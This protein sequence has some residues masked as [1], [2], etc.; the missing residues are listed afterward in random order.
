[1]GSL[2]RESLKS[3]GELLGRDTGR[4][5]TRTN[6]AESQEYVQH[7][8]A[9]DGSAKRGMKDNVNE[10]RKVVEKEVLFPEGGPRKI[11]EQ[12]SHLEANDDQQRAEDT[13][14]GYEGIACISEYRVSTARLLE[15]GDAISDVAIIDVHRIDL[16]KAFQRCFRLTRG[17]LGNA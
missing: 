5:G 6:E 3:G 9:A 16:G 2:S 8:N 10:R 17:F 7:A 13:V 14:H 15:S 1:M 12:G 4:T 11:E